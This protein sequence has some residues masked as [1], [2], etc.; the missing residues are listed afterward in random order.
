MTVCFT[1]LSGGRAARRTVSLPQGICD[2][3]AAHLAEFPSDELV[4]TSTQGQPIR[5]SNFR[6]RYW[7]PA[8]VAA[9][10]P[11]VRFHDLRHSH[12]S[13]LIEQGEHSKVISSRLGHSKI[14]ITMDIYGHLFD[15]L[16]EAAADVLDAVFSEAAVPDVC[17]SEDDTVV[18]MLG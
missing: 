3:I 5:W 7:K 6:R 15:G 2:L 9:G 17:H 4:F 11:D 8:L 16:D 13:I 18:D 12:A 1:A 10:L 14:G